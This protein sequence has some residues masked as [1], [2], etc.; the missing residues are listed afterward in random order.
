MSKQFVIGVLGLAL[1]S[2]CS[3]LASP[4]QAQATAKAAEQE[5]LQR[6]R[7]IT[8]L[9]EKWQNEHHWQAHQLELFRSPNTTQAEKDKAMTEAEISS[10]KCVEYNRESK[11]R[12]GVPVQELPRLLP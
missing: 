10:K 3:K 6:R 11:Q 12:Y 9:Y 4:E 1:C 7:E 5:K 2:G 8:D